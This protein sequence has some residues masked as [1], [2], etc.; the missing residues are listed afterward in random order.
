MP[1]GI[2]K[3]KYGN[4]DNLS[5]QKEIIKKKKT[6]WHKSKILNIGD[7]WVCGCVCWGELGEVV[8]ALGGE[9]GG[10]GQGV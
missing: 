8:V 6:I 4:E 7:G 5:K 3:S 9:G 1:W 10:W 2:F